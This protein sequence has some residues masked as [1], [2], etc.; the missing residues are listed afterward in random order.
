MAAYLANRRISWR[1]AWAILTGY[2]LVLNVIWVGQLLPS[3]SILTRDWPAAS[4]IYRQQLALLADRVG[5]WFLAVF[6]GDRTEETIVFALALSLTAWFV[7]AGAAW[8]TFRWRRPLPILMIM[9]LLLAAN[10]FYGDA[11]IWSISLY[12][13]L[14]ILLVAVVNSADLEQRWESEEVDY[15]DDIRV[16]LMMAAGG[17][18]LLIMAI[19]IVVPAINFRTISQAFSRQPVIQELE[20]TWDRIFAG[21][22]TAEPDLAL[23]QSSGQG[24]VGAL[25]RSF[26]LGD[27]P[28]LSS[29]VA[30]RAA[31][32]QTPGS[33]IHWRGA[34]YDIYTGLGWSISSERQ[35]EV[36]PNEAITRPLEDSGPMLRQSI[37]RNMEESGSTISAERQDQEA[38]I[39][40]PRTW[41]RQLRTNCARRLSKQYPLL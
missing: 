32:D 35:E 19:S 15:P 3:Q 27:P 30:F 18:M 31:V 37:E 10:A 14:A 28:E 20:D 4:D 26:L 24:G 11:P 9:A 13:G 41:S 1:W 38:A 2:G 21:V 33:T 23:S 7:A 22:R 25:P 29:T 39:R 5:G 12:F 34:S 16:D 6:S 36:G 8:S 17:L 40:P